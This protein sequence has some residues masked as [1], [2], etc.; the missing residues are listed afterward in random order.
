MSTPKPRISVS[1]VL[2]RS[3]APNPDVCEIAIRAAKHL[4]TSVDDKV[5]GYQAKFAH[6][7]AAFQGYVGLETEMIVT[8]IMDLVSDAGKLSY[9]TVGTALRISSTYSRCY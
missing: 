1:Y 9:M 6:L 7:K 5:K 2:H 3:C 4:F 8:R